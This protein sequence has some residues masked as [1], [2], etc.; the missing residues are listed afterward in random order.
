MVIPEKAMGTSGVSLN[1][2]R[3]KC[4]GM[5]ALGVLIKTRDAIVEDAFMYSCLAA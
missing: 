2:G 3:L 1:R 4:G 5:L